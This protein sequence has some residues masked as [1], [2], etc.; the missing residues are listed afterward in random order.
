MVFALTKVAPT[1]VDSLADYPHG[2]VVACV[3]IVAAVLIWLVVKVLKWTLWLLLI[4]VLLV[5]GAAVVALLL[6]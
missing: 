2:F 3:T 5:G 4:T 6:R 1:V